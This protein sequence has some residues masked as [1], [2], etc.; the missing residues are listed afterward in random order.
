MQ[1]YLS[2]M[3]VNGSVPSRA[4]GKLIVWNLKINT[5]V[6][7]KELVCTILNFCH[8]YQHECKEWINIKIW[9]S[10]DIKWAKEQKPLKPFGGIIAETLTVWLI[11]LSPTMTINPEKENRK[12]WVNVLNVVGSFSFFWK[13][14]IW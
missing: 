9:N 14:G 6:T 10:K 5:H 7:C 3:S 2:S 12:W 11:H 4:K 13:I 8:L 1:E